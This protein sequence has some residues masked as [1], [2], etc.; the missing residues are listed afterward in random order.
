M[1]GPAVLGWVEEHARESSSPLG[2]WGAKISVLLANFW[3]PRVR[4][5]FW[6]PTR[7]CRRTRHMVL[8]RAAAR[9]CGLP[10]F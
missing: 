3:F 7:Q 10:V 6:H 5:E 1:Y 9:R 2:L 8:A 4:T